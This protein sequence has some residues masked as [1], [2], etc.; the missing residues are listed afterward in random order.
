[1]ETAV[2]GGLHMASL[3]DTVN[4]IKRNYGTV[5]LGLPFGKQG[6]SWN[7][8]D[9]HLDTGDNLYRRDRK[10]ALKKSNRLTLQPLF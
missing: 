10:A 4:T 7:G 9:F 1:M 5:S 8:E 2:K 3:R 6:R